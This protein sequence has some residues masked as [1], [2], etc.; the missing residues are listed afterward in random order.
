M[1]ELGIWLRVSEEFVVVAWRGGWVGMSEQGLWNRYLGCAGTVVL[2]SV[3]TMI[4][5]RTCYVLYRE[6]RKQQWQSAGSL[7][8][9]TLRLSEHCLV[10][11]SHSHL[12]LSRKPSE[13][14][15]EFGFQRGIY[16]G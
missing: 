13:Y 8:K 11:A 3:Y 9:A 16:T 2:G 12:E 15:P 6:N 4:R 7:G 14:A 10:A 1:M 5:L